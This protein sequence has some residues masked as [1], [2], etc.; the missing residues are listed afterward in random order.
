MRLA[1]MSIRICFGLLTLIA[2]IVHTSFA[3]AQVATQSAAV[4]PMVHR[5]SATDPGVKGP[6]LVQVT[7]R[8]SLEKRMARSEIEP[9]IQHLQNRSNYSFVSD[10]PGAEN[11]VELSGDNPP[12]TLRP[13]GNP[14]LPDI[15]IGPEREEQDQKNA[16]WLVDLWGYLPVKSRG[17]IRI[18]QIPESSGWKL[19]GDQ[20]ADGATRTRYTFVNAAD[21]G[22]PSTRGK[23][24]V[25]AGTGGPM[26]DLAFSM[27]PSTPDGQV[28][29]ARQMSL[30]FAAKVPLGTPKDVKNTPGASK[31]ASEKQPDMLSA[32][33]NFLSY[34]QGGRLERM[35]AR[36]RVTGTGKGF[37]GV[38]YYSPFT[39]WFNQSR[40]FYGLEAEGGYRKGDA[41]FKDLVTKAPDRGNAVLRIGGVAEWAPLLGPVNRDLSQ[42]LRFFVRGRGWLDSYKNDYGKQT[43]RFAPFIDS[44]LF[45]N[46]AKDTRVFLRIEHG[47]LP[48]DLTERISRTY[49]GVGAAF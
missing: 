4:G 27:V 49:V 31:D 40:G 45:Y 5:S 2:A 48:P 39:G 6:Q 15:K 14:Q 17:E 20:A 3:F 29:P 46:F 26:L 38:G 36:A 11:L 42:G 32:D 9:L 44:E 33:L 13:A 34:K 8:I 23:A 22:K 47:S 19:T 24:Q 16:R 37:E 25:G 41:E 30:G 1:N 21:V 35:G 10:W 7:I 28:P 18:A 12:F 43:V